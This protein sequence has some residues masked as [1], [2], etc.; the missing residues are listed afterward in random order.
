MK[1]TVIKV[2]TR[3]FGY[4]CNYQIFSVRS[5]W[6]FSNYNRETSEEGVGQERIERIGKYEKREAEK[7]VKKKRGGGGTR[8]RESKS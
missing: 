7:M 1:H 4:T 5:S 2:K 8:G 3:I 6:R